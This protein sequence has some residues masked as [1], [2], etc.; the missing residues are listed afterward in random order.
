MVLAPF[1]I[2]ETHGNLGWTELHVRSSP[3]AEFRPF[4]A[5]KTLG[6]GQNGIADHVGYQEG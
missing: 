5:G 3:A 1:R 6:I 2:A 4:Q